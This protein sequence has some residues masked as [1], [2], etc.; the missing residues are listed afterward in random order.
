MH[1]VETL[2][3]GDD[4]RLVEPR[5]FL[6]RDRQSFSAVWAAHAGPS[7]AVPAVDFDSR[8]VAAVFAGERPSAGFSITVTG[9]RRERVADGSELVVLV[10]EQVPDP[11][12]VAAQIIVSPF[13]IATLPRDDGQVRFSLPDPTGQQTMIFKAPPRAHPTRGAASSAT[14]AKTHVV[15]PPAALEEVS[16]FTGLRPHVAGSLAYLAGPLSGALLLAVEPASQFVRFHAWQAVI[17]LGG[18]ALAAVS[19]LFLAFVLLLVSP[20][21]FWTMLWMAAI[22]AVA[23]VGVW[24]LCLVNA[25]KGRFWKLPYVGGIAAS[26]SPRAGVTP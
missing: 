15:M 19:F 22:T 4:S 7:A 25:F 16:S 12:R 24:A 14:S 1:V 8:M 11:A 26:A 3:R 2:A 23:W 13:H 18:L 9:T 10:D 5:R 6:I 17:G 21:A 20:A